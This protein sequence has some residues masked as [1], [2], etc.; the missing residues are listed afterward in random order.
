[1]RHVRLDHYF[2]WKTLVLWCGIVFGTMTS[3]VF[4]FRS[5]TMKSWS[6][7]GLQFRSPC[8]R[9]CLINMMKQALNA[10][11]TLTSYHIVDYLLGFIHWRFFVWFEF[12]CVLVVFLLFDVHNRRSVQH[13]H[14][15]LPMRATRHCVRV[16]FKHRTA[17]TRI[18]TDWSLNEPLKQ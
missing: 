3:G 9:M 6:S 14:D 16:H 12:E 13:W 11:Y 10:I 7:F 1:M 2:Q 18:A 15:R 17:S 8:P 5:L 4:E